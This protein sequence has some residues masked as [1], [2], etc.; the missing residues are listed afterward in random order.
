MHGEAF[1]LC[2]FFDR[3]EPKKFF[4]TV[5]IPCEYHAHS[6]SRKQSGTGF[7]GTEVNIV[8][9]ENKRDGGTREG[10]TANLV[11]RYG[12]EPR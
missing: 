4:L 1:I 7:N 3:K 5:I 11:V 12:D 10:G 2:G 8:K 9:D 6:K